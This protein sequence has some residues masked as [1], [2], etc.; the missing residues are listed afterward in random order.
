MPTPVR[1]HLALALVAIPAAT[2]QDTRAP[3]WPTS[4]WRASTPA[5]EGLDPAPLDELA[6]A[7]DA[8]TFGH[9]DRLF[10]ARRG[11]AVLDRRWQ[12]DYHV[13]GKGQRLGFGW[14]ADAQPVEGLPPEFNYLDADRHPYRKG[15]QLHTLQSVTKSVTSLLIGVAIQ[16]GAIQGIGSEL[17]PFFG[18]HD[19]SRVDAR[20]RQATLGDLLTMRTGIEWHETDRPLDR[21]NTTLQLEMSDDWIAFTL[22]QPMDAAPGEKWAYNSGASHLMSG[23][24]KHATGSFAD[25]FATEHLFAPLGIAQHYWKKD[26]QGFPDTEGG[27]YLAAE[28]LAKIGHLVLNDGV[29][30]G[31][32][33]LPEDWI[34]RSTQRHVEVGGGRGYGYQWWR[35][36]RDDVAVWAGMGFGGQLL[37]VLPAR[38]IVAVVCS[39]NVFGRRVSPIQGPVIETLVAASR[40]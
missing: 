23:V 17:L 39:W 20:L 15:T 38:G 34:A 7:I 18:D 22:A 28:D 35:L 26:P 24:L 32:R 16:R 14:G 12:H 3:S 8:G 11:R 13:I 6:A 29:W 37:L 33:L 10:V 5:A 40:E 21:T 9:V 4:G 19:T 2:A 1:L 30:D 27:L 31:E 25:A 36:D